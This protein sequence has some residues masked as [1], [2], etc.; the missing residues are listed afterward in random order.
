LHYYHYYYYHYY[1]YH[2]HHHQVTALFRMLFVKHARNGTTY[3]D[4]LKALYHYVTTSGSGGGSTMLPPSPEDKGQT[5]P[6]DEMF[7]SYYEEWECW[8]V[9]KQNKS[10]N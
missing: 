4:S 1:Y 3:S 5:I 6:T 7:H 2:Y 9:G 8:E 10:G